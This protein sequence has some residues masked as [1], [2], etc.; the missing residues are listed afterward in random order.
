MSTDLICRAAIGDR[1][2]E[3]AT[4][5][6]DERALYWCDVLRFLIHRYDWDSGSVR[7]WVFDEPVV[8]MSLTSR[9]GTLLVALASR[10]IFW[11][12]QTDARTP[13][14]FELESSP[15]VRFNDGR[16]DPLGN[17]WV[18]TMKNNVEPDGELGTVGPGEG[19]LFRV[20]PDGTVREAVHELGI[21]NTLC[22]SPDRRYF[23][24]ADTLANE[25]RRYDYDATRGLIANPEP[26]LFGM[27]LGV[28]DGSAMDAEG[29]LWNCRFG[30]GCVLRVS[31]E[32]RI[33]RTLE[34]PVPNVTTCAFGG[35]DLKTL[36]ITTAGRPHV[37]GDR[38][39]GSL[40]SLEV[41]VPGLPENLFRIE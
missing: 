18:G 22:W 29:Y 33:V 23:Y 6:A 7:S 34:M 21:A 11:E 16:A 31:P 3:A 4:W 37:R 8:A 17:F 28:P 35:P 1:C 20:A 14:G 15:R 39:A 13:H 24:F 27:K 30:G 38:L 9:P 41:P 25:I 5:S 32:G 40:F 2:G 12:P 10:L 19:I 26:F 36:F